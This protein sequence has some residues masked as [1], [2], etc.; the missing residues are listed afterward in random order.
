MIDT[1]IWVTRSRFWI[2]GA[3]QYQDGLSMYAVVRPS[4]LY[5]VNHYTSKTASY[6]ETSHHEI[7]QSLE[8]VKIVNCVIYLKFRRSLGNTTVTVSVQLNRC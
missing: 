1:D 6:I 4:N 3:S 7:S 2:L 5:N 8:A